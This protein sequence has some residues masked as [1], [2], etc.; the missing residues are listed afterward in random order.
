MEKVFEPN[1]DKVDS[2]KTDEKTTTKFE[3]RNGELKHV[4]RKITSDNSNPL[5]KKKIR[6]FTILMIKIGTKIR[7]WCTKHI[8]KSSSPIAQFDVNSL[9]PA[10]LTLEIDGTVV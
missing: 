10:E 1:I 3:V 7:F 9:I 4:T 6:H 2:P 5:V 8:Y